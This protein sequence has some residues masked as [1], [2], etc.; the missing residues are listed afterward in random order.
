[1]KQ[2]VGLLLIGLLAAVY[3]ARADEKP[4]P[5][6]FTLYEG[7]QADQIALRKTVRLQVTNGKTD[8]VKASSAE[9]C[10]AAARVFGRV[11]FLFK[12]R[13][14]VLMLLGDPATISDYNEQ[15]E[16]D[17]DK[18]LVYVFSSGLGGWRFKLKFRRGLCTGVEAEDID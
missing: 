13:D 6:A 2:A 11:S 18:P 5:D 4:K 7:F 12:K 17:P 10:Q 14:D 1:M 3:A 9:A 16:N 8:T 15:A